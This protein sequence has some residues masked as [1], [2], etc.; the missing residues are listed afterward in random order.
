MKQKNKKRLKIL[1]IILLLFTLVVGAT[2]SF[3]TSEGDTTQVEETGNS[4][5]N[6]LDVITGIVDGLLGFFLNI[7]NIIPVMIGGIIQMASVSIANIGNTGTP[8]AFLQLDDIL[9]NRVPI[10][11]VN[12]FAGGG[13]DVIVNIRGSIAT[14]YYALRNIAIIL[15]LAVLIYVGIRMAISTLAEDKAKY[16]K[17]LTDWVVGFITIFLLHYIIVIAVNVNDLLVGIFNNSTEISGMGSFAGDLALNAVNPIGG[18]VKGLT[19]AILYI[20]I[21][22]LTMMFLFDYIKRMLTVAFLMIIAPII[23]VTYSIDK[24]GDGKSQA[25]NTWLKEFLYNILIQ[26][27]HCIIY[28]AFMTIIIGLIGKP[29]DINWFD[30]FGLGASVIAIVAMLFIKQAEPIVRKIFGFDNASSLGSVIASGA[31]LANSINMAKSAANKDKGGKDKKP[32]KS[33]SGGNASKPQP[34]SNANRNTSN[35]DNNEN[36]SNSNNN[37][38]NGQDANSQNGNQNGNSSDNNTNSESQSGNNTQDSNSENNNGG[39]SNDGFSGDN[40]SN[41]GTQETED[42]ELNTEKIK[43]KRNAG[44]IAKSMCRLYP[45]VLKGYANAVSR[46]AGIAIG[47]MASENTI[48]GGITGFHAGKLIQKGKDGVASGGKRVIKLATRK[49]KLKKETNQLIDKYNAVKKSTGWDD[50]TM[51]NA[52]KQYLNI[53]NLDRETNP[54]LR[55]YARTLHQYRG[56]FEGRYKEPT[57]MVLNAI[58]QIQTGE[59]TKDKESMKRY[60]RKK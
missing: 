8:F 54:E 42:R 58:N 7:L 40:D 30:G 53:N 52:S 1:F 29:T 14:W 41:D 25:L 39:N 17:M 21:T 6:P 19:S 59:L 31:L 22:V 51:Y 18:F 36:G 60:T 57:D 46:V 38:R 43:N 32:N 15:S 44:D 26:P 45:K 10:L 27:F 33:G 2:S 49:P 4:G 50:A 34:S 24:M 13:A 55:D 47:A 3:A 37:S 35:I 12:F 9:F 11:S 16:K 48:T 28:L 20:F 56:Q 5:P 23:T